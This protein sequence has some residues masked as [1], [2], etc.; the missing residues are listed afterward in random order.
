MPGR[1]YFTSYLSCS[2]HAL[3]WTFTDNRTAHRVFN[4]L[5]KLE[6]QILV[7]HTP[8]TF[9]QLGNSSGL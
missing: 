2:S 5:K 6:L 9:M 1:G 3:L 4:Y 7:L 8:P